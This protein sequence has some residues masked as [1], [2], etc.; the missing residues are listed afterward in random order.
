MAKKSRI[1]KVLITCLL[2]G[3]FAEA[4]EPSGYRL[5]VVLVVD[6]F[7]A[8]YLMRFRQRFLAPGGDSKGYRF[9][10]E[11][12]AYF[13]LADHGLLADMTGPGHAA[14]LSGT[15]PY[16]HGIPTNVWF[17][18]EK[19]REVYCVEDEGAH[20]I[21]SDGVIKE[22]RYGVSPRGF[23]ASTVGDELKNVDR[24]SRV[25]SVSLKDRAAILMGGKRT[26]F[27]LWFD[28]KRCQWMSSDFYLSKLPD[29]ALKENERLK[30]E[31]GKKFDF[32]DQK[33]IEVCSKE[34]LRSPWGIEETFN[35][36]L[37]ATEELGLGKGKDTDLLLVSLSSHDFLGHQLGPNHPNMEE[38]TIREDRLISDFLNRL[39]KKVPGGMKD[40]FVV[41]T[42]DHGIPP[43][44]L[45]QE[46]VQSE[47]LP[48]DEIT[49]HV[50]KA[51]TQAFGKPAG[52]KWVD[53]E[54]EL[55][56][57]LNAESLK[58]AKITPSQAVLPVREA[59][60]KERFADQVWVRDE[61]VYDRKV[62]A[63]TYGVVADRTLT[64]RSGDLIVVLRPYYYS[65]PYPITHM[66]FYSYDRYV[67]LVFYGKTFKSGTYR[68][69]VNVVD[70]AP[71]LSSVLNVIPP[72]QSEGR[73]LT[74]ALR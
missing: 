68:Q 4:R 34:S 27:T 29:F 1:F 63:G 6:Q 30:S 46:R 53:A 57:Y 41:L 43:N 37:A 64:R 20:G 3:S 32:A 50:E 28:D 16:R 39:S 65:D 13:P 70:I 22:K 17:D 7:R 5:G 26:D 51:L 31:K 42:G 62:P 58:S 73:V 69:I 19:K 11:K 74:E 2:L 40:V 52:G 8:D 24:A 54:I 14:I 15:Y 9:L 55:Q 25:V 33:N 48:G 67:P 12:G 49:K 72:S 38:M 71:T 66:T 47:N 61:I 44:H 21:G 18:R 60:L 56:I 35:F 45:P 59:L 23:N 10:T 36:A